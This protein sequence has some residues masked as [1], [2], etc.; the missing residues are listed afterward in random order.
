MYKIIVG[1]IS[2]RRK[3]NWF[4]RDHNPYS[5]WDGQ[6]LSAQEC[7]I[8]ALSSADYCLR[9]RNEVDWGSIAWKGKRSEIE[10]LF[11][12]EGLDTAFLGKLRNGKDYAVM[13]LEYSWGATSCA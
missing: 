3:K 9:D 10:R 11:R 2:H 6:A 8:S 7:R 1:N 12:A 13:F 5:V 4:V